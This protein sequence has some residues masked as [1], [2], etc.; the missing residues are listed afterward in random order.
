MTLLSFGIGC[1]LAVLV[2]T[3]IISS[4]ITRRRLQA[5]EAQHGCE[6]APSLSGWGFKGLV[7]TRDFIRALRDEQAPPLVG[8]VLDEL[9]T[10]A[11]IH[12]ARF[13]GEHNSLVREGSLC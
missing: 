12:T 9:G 10:N 11:N 1:G 7:Q 4:A 5:A 8:K 13:N 3:R 6:P 2:L